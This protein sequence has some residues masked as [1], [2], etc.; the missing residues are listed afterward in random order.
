MRI[1]Y[2]FTL[3]LFLFSTAACNQLLDY[4]EEKSAYSYDF[5]VNGCATGEKNFSSREAMCDA[6]TNDSLNNNCAENERYTKFLSDC[7]GRTWQKLEQLFEPLDE[8]T[9]F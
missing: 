7:P 2:I 9:S 4:S 5:N 3:V 8:T 1:S 6:L